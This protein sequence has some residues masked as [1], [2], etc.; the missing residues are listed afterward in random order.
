MAI[1][2]VRPKLVI[3][4]AIP[5]LLIFTFFSIRNGYHQAALSSVIDVAHGIHDKVDPPPPPPPEPVSEPESY[6]YYKSISEE[7]PFQIVDNFPIALNAHSASD[8]PSIPAWNK[9]P[10]P[11]VPEQTPVFIGFTRNWRLLQQVVVSYITAGWPPEDIYVVENTGVMNS[12]VEGRLS[13]QNPFFLNH[14]RL[15]MFGVNVI[16][17][18]TLF[19]FAQLQNFFTYTALQKGWETYWW[20]HMD[21]I[22]VSNEETVPYSSLYN[23]AVNVLREVLSPDFAR[24]PKTNEPGHWSPIFHAYDQLALV[25]TQSYVEVGGWDTQIPFYMTDCD[26][27][28]R[29]LM[30]EY[31]AVDRPLGHVWDV[32]STLDDLSVLYRKTPGPVPSFIDPET[33][34]RVSGEEDEPLS[35]LEQSRGSESRESARSSASKWKDD[36]LA[37][38]IYHQILRVSG[39][40]MSSKHGSSRGRNTWQSR[41]T[42]GKGEPFYRDPAGFEEG[43]GLAI[44]HGRHVF[45]EKWGH[46]DCNIKEVGLMPGDAWRVEHDWDRAV[47]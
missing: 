5:L 10:S 36:E 37:S 14:T 4:L 8:L 3:S 7:E 23:N 41:Q 28:S 43:I 27:H 35:S 26:M 46:R 32:A 44:E 33:M 17:T 25:R 11:H 22:L 6:P 21:A 29:L 34:L 39:L 9:P 1:H 24:H 42:G 18:P 40:I 31:K 13:L 2:T 20:G 12:N 47:E 38:P 45:R 15:A 30:E 16:T 19:T